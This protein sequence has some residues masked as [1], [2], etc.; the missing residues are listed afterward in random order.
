MSSIKNP[1][2]KKRIAYL[3]DHCYRGCPSNKGWRKSKP[4]KKAKAR[5]AFRKKANDLARV[6]LSEDAAPSASIR[7]QNGTRQAK[8]FDWGPVALAKFVAWKK[9][10]REEMIGARKKRMAKR[11]AGRV[12]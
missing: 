11:L 12:T 3:H 1:L 10:K 8:V 9:S 2:E 5:R 6:C 4:L 7:K